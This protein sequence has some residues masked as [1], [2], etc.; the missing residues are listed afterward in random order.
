MMRDQV[1]RVFIFV[2]SATFRYV[3]TQKFFLNGGQEHASKNN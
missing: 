3:Y 1:K 2:S